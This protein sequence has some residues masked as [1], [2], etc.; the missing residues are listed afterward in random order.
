MPARGPVSRRRKT[1]GPGEPRA[2]DQGEQYVD[3]YKL[4]DTG[5]PTVVCS[6]TAGYA[7]GTHTATV[8]LS[9]L[10]DPRAIS[11]RLEASYNVHA[12]DAGSVVGYDD[13]PD[14]GYAPV[15]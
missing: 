5:D 9:C 13:A 2:V 3:V 12:G 11:Y 10:G 15:D 4:T 8:A 1:T 6:G 14:D 7:N